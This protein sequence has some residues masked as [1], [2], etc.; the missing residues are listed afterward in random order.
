M[1]EE[2]P[3]VP[4]S[5]ADLVGPEDR[6]SPAWELVM[7][8]WRVRGNPTVK[9]FLERAYGAP[10]PAVQMAPKPGDGVIYVIPCKSDAPKAHNLTL[11]TDHRTVNWSLYTPLL[12]FEFPKLNE[13]YKAVFPCRPERFGESQVLVID[14]SRYRVERIGKEEQ[15]AAAR[16]LGADP[17]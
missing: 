7:Y 9:G 3:V 17:Q 12:A 5:E 4:W 16:E 8:G 14:V 2:R 1:A 6:P 13:D 15:V 11:S 10:A